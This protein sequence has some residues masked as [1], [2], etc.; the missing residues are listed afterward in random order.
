MKLQKVT[1]HDHSSKYITT[2]V[3]NKLTAET[4]ATRLAQANLA[5]KKDFFAFA[6]KRDFDDKQ[7]KKN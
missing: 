5:I 6:K 7:K 4:F 1:D 2:P 3:F